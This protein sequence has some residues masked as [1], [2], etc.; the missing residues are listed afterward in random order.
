MANTCSFVGERIIV[1]QEK[2]STAERSWTYPLNALQEAIHYSFITVCIYSVSLWYEF[3]VH[4]ALKVKKKNY[5]LGLD[6]GP[7][8]FQFLQLRVCLT[9]PLRILSLYFGVI[10]KTPGLI[11]LNNF[12]TKIFVRI[13]HR[14]K[15]LARCDLISPLLSC[16]G[17]R[18]KSCT[19]LS[20]SQILFQ[21]PR[22]YSLGDCPRFR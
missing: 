4:Y 17:V 13:G 14:D 16:Q 7:L 22:N 18:K 20:L 19:Q 12:V 5:Q 9:N 11:S 1:Q 2:V 8:E 3:F 15:V 21:N 6:A 10:G